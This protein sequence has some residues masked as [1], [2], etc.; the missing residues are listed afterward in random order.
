MATIYEEISNYG[1]VAYAGPQGNSNARTVV[2]LFT[3]TTVALLSFCPEGA[4]PANTVTALGN[5]K[6]LYMVNYPSSQ[7]AAVVDILRNE[8]PVRFSFDDVA[9]KSY[10]AAGPE[11]VGENE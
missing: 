2:W 11:P 4:V 10:I 8:K 3:A 6:S 9:M 7:Y 1:L 5:G